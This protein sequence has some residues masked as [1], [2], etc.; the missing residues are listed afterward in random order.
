MSQI[1]VKGFT[2]VNPSGPDPVGERFYFYVYIY[3]GQ[4]PKTKYIE[5]EKED[6]TYRS[7]TS[8]P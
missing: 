2:I 3:V 1:C 8:R 7:R 6:K 4:N 5:R